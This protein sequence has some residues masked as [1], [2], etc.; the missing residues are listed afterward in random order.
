MTP[1]QSS[2]RP[3]SAAVED[4]RAFRALFPPEAFRQW[5][6]AGSVRRRAAWVSDVDH[7]VIPAFGEVSS[8]DLFGTPQTVNLVWHHLDAL[9][10]GRQV[11]KWTRDDGRTVW[12]DLQRAVKFRGFKHEIWTADAENWGSI[13]AIR[14]GPGEFSH[15]MV[16]QLQM[17]GF[18]NVDGYV[19]NNHDWRCKCGWAGVDPLWIPSAEARLK[20]DGTAVVRAPGREEEAAAYCPGCGSGMGLIRQRVP[21][22]TEEKYFE[23]VGWPIVAPWKRRVPA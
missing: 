22:P 15:R 3:L 5:K 16:I 6:G 4:A 19:V 17:N 23:L 2:K 10:A 11:E 7:V 21:V 9:V 14:T 20:L 1:E 13:L 18:A 12:G 8:G